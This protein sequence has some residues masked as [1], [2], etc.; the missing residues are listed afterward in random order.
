MLTVRPRTLLR[1]ALIG[2]G[3]GLVLA[4]GMGLTGYLDTST[5]AAKLR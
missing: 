1:E 5:P 2:F 4:L 3:F